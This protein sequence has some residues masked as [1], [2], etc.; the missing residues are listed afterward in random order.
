MGANED[1]EIEYD[2]DF[3]AVV[4][5]MWG[6]GFLSPGGPE[7]VARILEGASLV[8][9]RVLDVGCGTGGCDLEL[10][11]RHGAAEV[12]GIDVEPQLVER[13]RT[14]AKAK[15]LLDQLTFQLVEPGPFPF[16]DASFDFVFSKD[17]MI[18]IP[19]KDALYREVLRVLRPGGYFL[20]SDWLRGF[21]G[22]NSA[23]MERWMATADLTFA[24]TTPEKTAEA[25]KKAGFGEV[26]VRNCNR[27]FREQSSRDLAQVEGPA[28]TAIREV[29]GDEG[30]ER[31]I[32]RTRLRIEIVDSGELSPCHLKARKK[33]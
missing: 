7:E 31:Y 27:W 1:R 24:M 29:W 2:D 11:Q 12:V 14:L 28:R 4:E 21:E 10:V 15:G 26:E 16:S 23:T 6:E 8:G 17:S 3:V 9:G 22:Q 5:A 33:G 30:V 32:H 13:C 20:A 25:M 19:D 18:H